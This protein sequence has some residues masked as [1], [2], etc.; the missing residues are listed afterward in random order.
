[1]VELGRRGKTFVFLVVVVIFAWPGHQV[2][3]SVVL[4]TQ[5]LE[6]PANPLEAA[7]D[8][9]STVLLAP[10]PSSTPSPTPTR[11]PMATPVPTP[12]P[13]RKFPGGNPLLVDLIEE[14]II[15]FTNDERVKAGLRPFDHDVAISDIA[16]KHSK[17]MVSHGLSHT[18]V[19]KDPTDR[20]LTAGYDCRA[21]HGD[22]SYSYGLSENIA[23]HPRVRHWVGTSSGWSGY[24]WQ[25]TVYYTDA[26]QAAHSLVQSWMNS[27]GH[28]A[29]ML[30]RDSRKIGV[31]VAVKLSDQYGWTMETL[32][33]TQNFSGCK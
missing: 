20:A 6:Q 18:I 14:W 29:N 30:D 5:V 31:G 26:E 7:D 23:E 19:G 27:P 17:R 1:M 24:K 28:R 4:S 15:H 33:A 13:G 11:A 16:R 2:V 10:S 8:N 25:P 32:Y 3:T 21:Y 22:G 9:P 12:T